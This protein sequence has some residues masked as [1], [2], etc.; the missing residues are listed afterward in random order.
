MFILFEAGM[1]SFSEPQQFRSV[2]LF[3]VGIAMR[4]FQKVQRR[5]PATRS[6]ILKYRTTKRQAGRLKMV[7]AGW[8]LE[9][10]GQKVS[11]CFHFHDVF[12]PFVRWQLLRCATNSLEVTYCTPTSCW[13]SL[14]AVMARISDP[15]HEIFGERDA[16]D[17][18]A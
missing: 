9:L 18:Q 17:T 6:T 4:L 7:E 15:S 8:R 5:K 10:E 14:Q 16:V 1:M 12:Y 2:R 13:L 11:L 3:S